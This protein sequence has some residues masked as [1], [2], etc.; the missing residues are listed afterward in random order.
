MV[1]IKTIGSYRP[2]SRKLI[3]SITEEKIRE[4]LA[5]I[6]DK[7]G[8]LKGV[9]NVKHGIKFSGRTV[10]L[11]GFLEMA[12]SILGLPVSMAQLSPGPLKEQV[13]SLTHKKISTYLTTIGLVRFGIESLHK[14]R[15]MP[16]LESGLFGRTL[17][18]FKEIYQEYF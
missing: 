12:E 7:L 5:K 1:M 4:M 15:P 3:S 16:T 13:L 10:L 17:N 2:I 6:S 14:K 9:E 8:G 18:R 11:E